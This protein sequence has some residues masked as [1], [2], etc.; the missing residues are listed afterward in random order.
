MQATTRGVRDNRSLGRAG[1]MGAS[2][3]FFENLNKPPVLG[4][5]SSRTV[6][7]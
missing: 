4:A 1:M 3:G 6:V 7:P 5:L 2:S